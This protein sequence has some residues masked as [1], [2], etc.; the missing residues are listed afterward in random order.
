MATTYILTIK[1]TPNYMLRLFNVVATG[2]VQLRPNNAVKYGTV[3]LLKH[4]AVCRMAGRLQSVHMITLASTT[5][6]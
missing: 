4:I 3:R 1:N 5:T 2:C 6:I